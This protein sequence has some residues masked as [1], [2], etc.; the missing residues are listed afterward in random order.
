[1]SD[2]SEQVPDASNALNTVEYDFRTYYDP[3]L[4]SSLEL[5]NYRTPHANTWEGNEM[6]REVVSGD[7]QP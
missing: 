1:M 7:F 3:N 5:C 6:R 2:D 4:G